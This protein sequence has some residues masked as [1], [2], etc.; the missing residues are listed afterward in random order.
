MLPGL[1]FASLHLGQIPAG[2]GQTVP[3][4]VTR[5]AVVTKQMV[6]CKGDPGTHV[7]VVT[8]GRVKV[9]VPS[10]DGKELTL[11]IL[12]PGEVFGELAVLE[13]K[14][15][16]ATV[17][18]LERTEV[19]VIERQEFLRL[20]EREPAIVR[21][22]LA[23]LCA[24]LRQTAEL[25]QDISSLPLPRRLAKKLLALARTYGTQTPNGLRIGL[26]LCQQEL[27][28]LVG[29][30]RES[31]NKQLGAWQAGGLIEVDQGLIT[32]RRLTDAAVQL[33]AQRTA[34]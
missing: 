27:A 6:Y 24:R 10:E 12:E 30:S 19:A 7:Y 32:I 11:G 23:T 2:Q 8:K 18:A 28:N 29:T 9:T 17:V 13:G 4:H 26:H 3:V 21:A 25:A 5:Q 14:E 22:L 16:A 34:G 20:L 33:C 15:H 1:L 31:V